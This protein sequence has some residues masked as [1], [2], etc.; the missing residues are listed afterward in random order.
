LKSSLL[1]HLRGASNCIILDYV[2]FL[3]P[4]ILLFYCT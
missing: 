4:F 3:P 2:Q 1:K